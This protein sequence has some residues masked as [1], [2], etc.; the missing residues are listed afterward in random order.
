MFDNKKYD[1]VSSNASSPPTGEYK[2]HR[3]LA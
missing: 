1:N 2:W 3:E